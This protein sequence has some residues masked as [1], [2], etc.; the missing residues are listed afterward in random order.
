M[1]RGVAATRPYP[2]GT[3]SDPGTRRFSKAAEEPSN[4]AQNET[5][6]KYARAATAVACQRRAPAP[7]EFVHE[8]P[9]QLRRREG[10]YARRDLDRHAARREERVDRVFAVLGTGTRAAGPERP[11][12]VGEAGR[13]AARWTLFFMHVPQRAV[14][15]GHDHPARALGSV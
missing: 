6:M 13:P 2:R 11:Q 5:R 15:S 14:L 1:T 7:C 12:I 3:R 4:R 10:N 9:R 8:R